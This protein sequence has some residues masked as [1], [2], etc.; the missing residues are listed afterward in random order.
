[1][2][3]ISGTLERLVTEEIREGSLHHGGLVDV[4]QGR[5]WQS[6]SKHLLRGDIG[7]SQ[8]GE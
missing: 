8:A 1:M 7:R 5:D 2:T 6:Y 3:E 4:R